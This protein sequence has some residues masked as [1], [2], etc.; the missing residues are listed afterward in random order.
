MPPVNRGFS[1]ALLTPNLRQI[2]IETGK[3]RPLEF[4]DV[5]NVSDM[6]WNPFTDGQFAGLG[7]MPEKPEG[8]QF[9]TD[10]PLVG[11]TKTYTASPWGIAFEV[12]WE[13]W[14]DELYGLMEEMTRELKRS[15]KYRL[16]TEA[17][18]VLNNGFSTSYTGFEASKSLF[19]TTHNAFNYSKANRPSVEIGLSISGLQAATTNFENSTN[20]RGLP[21]LLVPTYIII[22]PSQRWVARE[23]LGSSGVPYKAD[24]EINS[25]LQEGLTYRVS[26]YKTSTTSWFMLAAKNEHDL[27]FF[28]RDHPM[29]DS[30]DDPTTKNAV[31]CC[32]QRTTQGYGSWRGT[33]GTTG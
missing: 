24:N 16:E 4:T 28:Y 25:L 20:A 6:E 18:S 31:F 7:A 5:F 21:M 22:G 32:Y 13:M 10:E 19:S 8:T 23:I 9:R 17:W 12:T 29:F 30:W 3:D 2:Y 15:S 11:G 33:Y 27:N 1:S 14:R 26:H